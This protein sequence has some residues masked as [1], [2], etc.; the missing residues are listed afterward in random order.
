[1]NT[2]QRVI[3]IAGLLLVALCAFFPPRQYLP[4][5]TANASGITIGIPPR[6]SFFSSDFYG[7]SYDSRMSIDVTRLLAEILIIGALTGIAFLLT[8]PSQKH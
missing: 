2:T 5:Q 3:L 6:V 8:T 4:Y 7:S 1:M